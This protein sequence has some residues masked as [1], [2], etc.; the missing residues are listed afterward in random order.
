MNQFDKSIVPV[1]ESI[2]EDLSVTEKT[3]A[4]FFIH[5]KKK[6]DFSSKAISKKLHVAESALTRF[7]KKCGFEGYRDF[8]FAYKNSF[9]EIEEKVNGLTQIVFSTYQ[10]MLNKNYSIINDKQIHRIVK[11]M[12]DANRVFVYGIGS[13]GMC[14]REFKIRFMRLGLDVEYVTDE[15]IMKMNTFLMDDKC[16][17]IGMSISGENLIDYLKG[18][19][20]VN[21]KTVFITANFRSKMIEYC[22][23]VLKIGSTKYLDS[24]DIISPQFSILV[25][26]DI[27]YS[28][29]LNSDYVNKYAIL[30]NTLKYVHN[31]EVDE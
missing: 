20:Q 29:F 9:L 21:A 25:M 15:H 27:L 23:E 22:D 10:D 17:L 13:S 18:A 16:L 4:D 8:I 1:L 3:I 26:I 31:D 6:M 5:N 24:V 7:S 2:Y 28:H 19:K 14:A 12:I 30:K 11:M